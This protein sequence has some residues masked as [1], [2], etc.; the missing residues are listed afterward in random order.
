[1]KIFLLKGIYLLFY[2]LIII[3]RKFSKDEIENSEIS[4]KFIKFNNK[5]VLKRCKNIPL[6]KISILLPHCI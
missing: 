4:K 2:F 5:I 6:N 3:A 1:M